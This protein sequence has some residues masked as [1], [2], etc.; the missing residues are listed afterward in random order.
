MASRLGLRDGLSVL[1]IDRDA[2]HGVPCLTSIGSPYGAGLFFC[3]DDRN[4]SHGTDG[5]LEK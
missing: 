4:D 2:A 3:A 1:L 5:H